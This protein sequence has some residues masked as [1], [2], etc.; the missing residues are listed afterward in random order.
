MTLMDQLLSLY[1]VDAQIRGLRSRLK[2][3]ERQ[4]AAQ[5]KQLAALNIQKLEI[6][7]QRR[8]AQAG[9][10]NLETEA[11]GMD[12]RIERLRS[13]LNNQSSQKQYA[14]ILNELNG[15]KAK[16]TEIDERTLADLERVEALG[17]EL[18]KLQD[19]INERLKV[20]QVS[21][22]ELRERE[23]EIADRLD[24]LQRERDASASAI[25]DVVMT[26]F[27]QIA[28]R[29]EGEAMAPVEELDRRSRD[30]T[31]SACNVHLPIETI[32][33]LTSSGADVVQCTACSRILYLHE[34]T[35]GAFA[36]K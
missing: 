35:R 17:G 9:A 27:S 13:D 19:G 16:R 26:L 5:D 29:Y 8:A 28:D 6:E 7:K 11:K 15:L 25:P 30:Y 36:R 1:R 24:E 21:E 12:E 32:A 23:A 10:A 22:K 2:A 31:C 20:R 3:A 33:R 18:A 14:A 34:E 4:I